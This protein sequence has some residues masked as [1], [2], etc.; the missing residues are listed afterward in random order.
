M[1]H[2]TTV[3]ATPETFERTF[4]PIVAG[5]PDADPD[6]TRATEV[7]W[8]DP[9]VQ[10]ALNGVMAEFLRL[11]SSAGPMHFLQLSQEQAAG[12]SPVAIV[13][14]L[15]EIRSALTAERDAVR[16]ELAGWNSNHTAER[17]KTRAHELS[18]DDSLRRAESQLLFVSG[19]LRSAPE[20]QISSQQKLRDAGL[21]QADISKI[22]VKPSDEDIS[23]WTAEV[24]ILQGQIERI[25]KF[26]ATRPYYDVTI[27]EDADLETLARWQERLPSTTL[28][29]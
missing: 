22:G 16:G 21:S 28:L 8:L 25:R 14:A 20:E 12:S 1:N 18:A 7:S 10:V 4:R 27:L 9:D 19:R 23:S 17:Q 11:S 6:Y 29:G 13:A 5:Q 24:G 2:N 26:F 3:P 15:D